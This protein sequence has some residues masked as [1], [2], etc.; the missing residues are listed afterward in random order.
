MLK[1]FNKKLS[2]QR[3]SACRQ[4]LCHSRSF[5]VT[6]DSTKWKPVCDFLLV[7]NTN[8]HPISHHFTV[9]VQ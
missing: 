8:L 3:N 7:N 2:Y 9:I 5:K 4:S 6:E 1:I